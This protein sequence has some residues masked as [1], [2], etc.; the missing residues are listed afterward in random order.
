MEKL[1]SWVK[2]IYFPI[3]TTRQ[4]FNP[5]PPRTIRTMN[6]LPAETAEHCA[7]GA[8]KPQ[9]G[10]LKVAQGN[11]LGSRTTQRQSPEGANQTLQTIGSPLQGFGVL[12]ASY[13]GRYPRLLWVAPLG[14][15]AAP[16]GA[17]GCQP[18]PPFLP[19]RPNITRPQHSALRA[20]GAAK[21]QRGGLKVAQGNAL[22]SRITQQQ[23][24]EGAI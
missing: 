15:A 11:A 3:P 4:R 17:R 9:R 18:R 20:D 12:S 10:G 6:P 14:L 16:D 1:S 22:G 2:V 7:D 8:A 21:P 19:T 13:L 23:S 24:P 5:H